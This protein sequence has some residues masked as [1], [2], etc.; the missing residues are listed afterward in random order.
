MVERDYREYLVKECKTQQ[1]HKQKMQKELDATI[2]RLSDA[3]RERSLKRV[4]EYE[5]K[6]CLEH[7]ELFGNMN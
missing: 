3:D 6:R 7:K 1:R 2:H 4:S 5:L